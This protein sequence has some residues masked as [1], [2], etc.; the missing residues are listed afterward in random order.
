MER[1]TLGELDAFSQLKAQL[2]DESAKLAAAASTA[3]NVPGAAK[4]EEEE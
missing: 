3:K 4:A 2:A 1:T